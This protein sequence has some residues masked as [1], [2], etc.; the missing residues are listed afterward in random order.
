MNEDFES[1]WKEVIM[2]YFRVLP[3]IRLDEAR[4]PLNP[5]LRIFGFP[6]VIQT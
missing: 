2:A 3:L 6:A 5:P 4:E 1:I